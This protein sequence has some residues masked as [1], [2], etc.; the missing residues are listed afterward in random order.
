[1]NSNQFRDR[2]E[3]YGYKDGFLN[4]AYLSGMIRFMTKAG[5]YLQQ[6][7][8]LG[9]SPYIHIPSS[10]VMPTRHKE[11]DL[12]TV[13]AR[14]IGVKGEDDIPT[15]R[16]ELIWVNGVTPMDV[17]PEA[18]FNLVP[19]EVDTIGIP[20]PDNFIVKKLTVKQSEG[21]NP[22]L[23]TDFRSSYNSV[24][25][26]G[27]VFAQSQARHN[28]TGEPKDD[29]YNLML[30]VSE[31]VE[32]CLPVKVARRDAVKWMAAYK[33]G[34]PVKIIGNLRVRVR[35]EPVEG[36]P[37]VERVV[38]MPYIRTERGPELAVRDINQDADWVQETLRKAIRRRHE[39]RSRKPT[40]TPESEAP[41]DVLAGP[42]SSEEI[43]FSKMK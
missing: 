2:L 31:D 33:T 37:D 23:L 28:I 20:T 29:A 10:V 34:V 39:E 9:Q 11:G 5:F 6:T 30:R 22:R 4:I 25:V 13:R 19:N 16:V 17:K 8:R 15:I 18:A 32:A 12:V 40:E 26:T 7:H 36:N 1:M 41:E 35:P 21:E 14:L 38:A 43:D 3:D 27:L 42:V 24:M